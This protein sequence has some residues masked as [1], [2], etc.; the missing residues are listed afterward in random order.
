MAAKEAAAPAAEHKE[1][2]GGG[3]NKIVLILSAVNSVVVIAMMAVLFISQQKEKKA[4]SITDISA[5]EE[6][7]VAE[8]KA[9]AHGGGGHGG[10]H[11]A[12]A[13][14]PKKTAQF[15]KIITLDMFTVNLSTPGGT[16]PRFVRV[17]ISIEVPSDEVEAEIT[18]KMPQVRNTIIDLFN[19]KRPTDLAT[20]DGR[21]Y[22]KDEIKNAVN[23]FLVTG[24][25][26]GV[27]FTNFA[28]T[29]QF[30]EDERLV[31]LIRARMAEL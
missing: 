2:S 17:N 6:A 9:D 18:H 31:G 23:G 24:K 14:A 10:G 4:A 30:F 5:Q 1:S 12:A 15:G 29:S 22:V 16:A 27:F 21:D 28:V 8:E 13:A 20:P 19:S 26:K 7:P 11:G 3:G 25:I